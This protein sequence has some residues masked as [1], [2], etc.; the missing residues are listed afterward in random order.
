ML[1]GLWDFLLPFSHMWL[2]SRE[3]NLYGNSISEKVSAKQDIMHQD[4][5]VWIVCIF[6]FHLFHLHQFYTSICLHVTAFFCSFFL[7]LLLL[8]SLSLSVSHSTI[9]DPVW[10]KTV[11]RFE[12]F[13]ACVLWRNHKRA[14]HAHTHTKK[15][16][17]RLMN[18][19]NS[20]STCTNS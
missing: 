9:S 5:S 1:Y 8:I 19:S 4:K 6:C 20:L 11:Q 3:L 14:P 15:Q 12:I 10:Q 16:H 17:S 2:M 7:L 18:V 13:A